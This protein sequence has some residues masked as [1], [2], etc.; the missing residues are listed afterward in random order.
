MA[1]LATRLPALVDRLDLFPYLA[2]QRHLATSP[3]DLAGKNPRETGARAHAERGDHRQPIGENPPKRGVRGYDGGKKG[4]GRKRHLLVDTN[5]L[6]MH[7][8]VH[9]ANIQDYDGGKRL[10]TPLKDC[11]PRLKHIWADSA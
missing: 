2:Q 3:Y 8:L 9:A 1:G 7:V 11:F 6:L 10:L 5:G 4:K